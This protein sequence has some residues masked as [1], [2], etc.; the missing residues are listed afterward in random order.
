MSNCTSQCHLKIIITAE[1]EYKN[2]ISSR[3][4]NQF[5]YQLSDI[6]SVDVMRGVFSLALRKLWAVRA[7]SVSLN[8]YQPEWREALLFSPAGTHHSFLSSFSSLRFLA[9]LC[10]MLQCS[11]T[12]HQFDVIL[13]SFFVIILNEMERFLSPSDALASSVCS[14]PAKRCSGL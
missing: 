10:R 9:L 12:G 2:D 8:L 1:E 5:L 4:T 6:S 7:L 14:M 3:Y 11:V 13:S